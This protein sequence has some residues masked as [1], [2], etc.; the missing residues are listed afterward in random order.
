MDLPRSRAEDSLRSF[1]PSRA[2]TSSRGDDSLRPSWLQDRLDGTR[3]R[4]NRRRG[5][6]LADGGRNSVRDGPHGPPAGRR[7]A[8]SGLGVAAD[9]GRLARRGDRRRSA[10][11]HASFARASSALDRAG[12]R[13]RGG[14]VVVDGAAD[15]RPR[16]REP[17]DE[18]GQRPARGGIDRVAVE[19]HRV[20]IALLG[21]RWRR[22]GCARPRAASVPRP[23]LPAAAEPD[24]RAT[25]LVARGSSTT[26]T[27]ASPTRWRSARPT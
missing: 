24:H 22:R 23:G 4:G 26:S 12:V 11:D 25:R 21:A 9:R 15:R 16:A 5:G 20:H 10:L 1:A 19:H 13:S 17:A 27:S 7:S 3:A 6:S 18:L 14:R 2:V 8:G